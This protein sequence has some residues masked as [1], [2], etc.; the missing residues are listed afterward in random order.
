MD[1]QKT[2]LYVK[3]K[4][5]DIDGGVPDQEVVFPV[6]HLLRSMWKQV[7]VFV[8]GKLISSGST[9]YHY[10]SMI[11]TLLNSC[12]NEG[13]KQKLCTELFYEDTPGAHDS[14]NNNPM[15]EGSY[16]RKRIAGSGNTFE[17]DGS[18][19]E[20][21]LNLENYII[22]YVDFDLKLYPV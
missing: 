3:C 16:Y 19:G 2:R 12:E 5:R 10:K 14:L 21:V 20:D 15:N 22:N 4:I 6:N 13:M 8:G 1:L 17:M 18:L 11:K 9:N 7:E